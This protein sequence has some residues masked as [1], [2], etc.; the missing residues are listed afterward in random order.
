MQESEL[1]YFK[2]ILESRKEQI[3]KNISG[4]NAELAQLSSLELNDEADHAAMNNNSMVE[5]AIVSQQQRELR[6]IDVTLAKIV[7][8]DY[9]ICEM[10]EDPIGFQRLKV[11][12]HAIYCI[13]CREIVEK[14][15]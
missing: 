14:S 15:S 11:K 3:I 8:G 9:G 4:V 12:P 7:K 5:S 6:E 1:N 2:E 13:D 10:C